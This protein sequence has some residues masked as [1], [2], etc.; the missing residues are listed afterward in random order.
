MIITLSNAAYRAQIDSVGAQLISLC[1]ADGTEY[2]WQRD[3][4]YW[5][6]CSPLLFPSVGCCRSGK[7]RIEGD[8][9]DMPKHGICRNAEFSVR[10][11]SEVQA[12]F[13]LE[14]SEET[15]AHYPYRFRLTLTYTLQDDG[16]WMD[17]LV[18]NT[19]SRPIHYC[20]GAHPGFRCPVFPGER[21]EDYVLEFEHEETADSMV[22][23][24][25]AEE[26]DPE[27]RIPLLSHTRILPLSYELFVSDAVFF[28]RLT[29]RSVTL[30][31]PATGFGIQVDF[32]DFETVAFWTAMPAKGPFLCVEPWNGSDIRTDEDDE[33]LHRH[34]LQ[35]LAVGDAKA[36][37][38]GIRVIGRG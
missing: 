16:I 14:D 6:S 19:D 20:I 11:E 18:E 37:H 25:A 1:A 2:I 28:D 22:F 7:T 17:Y 21:F 4:A 34:F 9:Y 29:S 13:L 33:F 26:F 27:K 5:K 8:W 31:H 24:L 38:L 23:D 15:R 30:K 3:P 35:S 12:A 32:P 36:Y 10:R